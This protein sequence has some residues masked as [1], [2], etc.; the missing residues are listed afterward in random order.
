V[1][2]IE[3]R[4]RQACVASLMAAAA[5]GAGWLWLVPGTLAASTFLGVTFTL[6][7][8]FGIGIAGAASGRPN[9]SITRVLLDIENPSRQ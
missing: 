3:G 7:A 5:E 2:T 6:V 8:M 9:R 4:S 1:L